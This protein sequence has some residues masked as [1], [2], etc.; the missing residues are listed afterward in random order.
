M[1]KVA[2]ARGQGLVSDFGRWGYQHQGVPV[3]GVLDRFS[4]TVGNRALGN[5]DEAA[6][7][8]LMGQFTLVCTRRGR[9]L[10]ANRGARATLN[11]KPVYCGQILNLQQADVLAL[12]PPGLGFWNLLCVQGGVDV[13]LVMGSRSTCLAGRFGGFQGRAL[14]V[15]DYLHAGDEFKEGF[16]A[17]QRLAMPSAKRNRL[18][19]LPVHCLAGPEFGALSEESRQQFTRQVY[20]L[21]Q[22]ISRMGYSLMG[23]NAPLTLSAGLS[24]R[25]HA[26]HPGVIQLPPSG[27]PVVLLSEAQVTG[28]YPRLAS[29]LSTE[30]WKLAQLGP[31]Q[32]VHWI[33]VDAA[34]ATRLQL[35]HSNEMRRY[36]HVIESNRGESHV[37]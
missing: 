20:T 1:F 34:Q 15:G 33:V 37:D 29:V 35:Q 9:V 3:G 26:V 16:D 2:K 14:E 13:P 17:S 11:G 32:G 21:G 5:P 18:G 8:E 25:S 36:H 23:A 27:H 31:G 28:G 7:L 24:M 12:L 22:Q 19:A 30:L 6:C 10:L 4:C